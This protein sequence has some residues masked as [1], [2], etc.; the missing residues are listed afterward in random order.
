MGSVIAPDLPS[1]ATP[2]AEKPDGGMAPER[3]TV[4]PEL[5]Q[6]L[7]ALV[8]GS[9]RVLGG[10]MLGAYLQGSFAVGDADEHSDCDFI[11]VTDGEMSGDVEAALRTFHAEFH[12]R[13]GPWYRGVEGSYVP[14]DQLRRWE[15]PLARWL[16]VDHQASADMS[17]STHC[18]TLVARW[19]MRERGVTLSGPPPGTLVGPVGPEALRLSMLP[20]LEAFFPNLRT[21]IDIDAVAW[22][23]R[24]A[25]VTLCRMLYTVSTGEVASKKASLLWAH[26]ATDPRWRPLIH[27]ALVGRQDGWHADQAPRPGS[28]VE[29]QTFADYALS[30]ARD[31]FD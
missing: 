30:Q 17:W 8:E 14:V 13:P 25:V 26:E 24:H 16:F 7:S 29:T 20:E 22:G 2:A 23:Q 21:W 10:Q 9:R 1:S 18:N 28:V 4:F 6:A 3:P 19:S 31:L 15:H 12:D 11:V 27:E 5:N